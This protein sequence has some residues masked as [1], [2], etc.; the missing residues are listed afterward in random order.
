MFSWSNC[1]DPEVNR[2]SAILSA[3]QAE[4]S[5]QDFI[6]FQLGVVLVNLV[7][8]AWKAVYQLLICW[9]PLSSPSSI[10]TQ[11]LYIFHSKYV[12]NFPSLFVVNTSVY[13]LFYPYRK[14]CMVLI[15]PWV[16]V[17]FDAAFLRAVSK[18]ILAHEPQL[19]TTLPPCWPTSL[20]P[21]AVAVII[22]LMLRFSLNNLLYCPFASMIETKDG[23]LFSSGPL[24]DSVS[25]CVPWMDQWRFWTFPRM[26]LEIHS[27]RRKRYSRHLENLWSYLRLLLMQV[28][29]WTIC[30]SV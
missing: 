10:S 1:L 7:N 9:R 5:Q 13:I 26:N 14:G 21:S 30:T 18:G 23:P 25:W 16:G 27:V 20:F 3:E 11:V 15:V 17:L 22:N 4:H 12:Y 29:Y 19:S 8:T 24:M 28:K 6:I 2:S